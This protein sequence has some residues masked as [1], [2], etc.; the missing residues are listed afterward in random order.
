MSNLKHDPMAVVSSE[1]EPLILVNS[2]DEEVGFANKSASHDGEGMLHRAFSI[3]IFNTQG[4]LLLQQRAPGKRLWGNYWSNS[5]CSHPRM[6]E[7]MEQATQRRLW[8]ELGLETELSFLYK[9]EYHCLFG[10]AGAEHEL[11]WVYV[12]ISDQE[13][14]TN[15]NEIAQWRYISQADLEQ[16]L[17]TTPEVFTPWFKLEWE[18]IKADFGQHLQ[19]RAS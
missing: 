12:G 10:D 7:S 18:R 15:T 8:E 9:F 17:A 1:S 5:C 3:L 19:P 6:G 4:E 13:P 2:Q 16:E 14:S 11:C